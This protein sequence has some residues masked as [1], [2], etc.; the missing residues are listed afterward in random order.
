MNVKR[1]RK[2]RKSYALVDANGKTIKDPRIDAINADLRAGVAID[3]LEARVR[4]VLDSYRPKLTPILLSNEQLV[5]ERHAKKLQR[6]PDLVDPDNLKYRLLRAAE[7]LGNTPIREASEDQ[8]YAALAHIKDPA[9]RFEIRRGINELLIFAGR[10]FKLVNPRPVRPDE[11]EFIRIA[12]FKE[13]AQKLQKHHAAYLGAL[14]ATGCRF[15]ELPVAKLSDRE[16]HVKAQLKEGGALAPTKNKKSRTA[17]ILPPLVEYVQAYR[18]LDRNLR[19]AMCLTNHKR[20]YYACKKFLGIRIHDLRHSYAVE[21]GAKG[22]STHEIARFVGDTEEVCERHY[23]NYCATPDEV[24]RV[25]EKW[26]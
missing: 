24:A 6:K 7:A 18:E 19:Y 11:I 26:K 1:P 8:I 5:L 20:I 15:A 3:L 2:D 25:L 21:W 17:P 4:A 22:C 16:V 10:T 14:F 9:V 12:D 23:R 13:K